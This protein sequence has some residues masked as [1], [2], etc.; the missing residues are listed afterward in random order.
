MVKVV[1][2]DG[3]RIRVVGTK[4][5]IEDADPELAIEWRKTATNKNE[6]YR[7]D[8][9]AKDKWALM[10]LVSRIGVSA[11]N[12][13]LGDGSWTTDQDAHVVDFAINNYIIVVLLVFS[14]L[15]FSLFCFDR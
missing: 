12:K 13:R 5:A 10:K 15:F 4:S 8:R 14:S 3:C 6:G 7:A 1:V 9:T 11:T 2:M